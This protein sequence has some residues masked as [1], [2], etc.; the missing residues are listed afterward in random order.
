[1]TTSGGV[2]FHFTEITMLE[3]DDQLGPIEVNGQ[4]CPVDVL[5]G[6]D[7]IAGGD[8]TIAL[9][10]DGNLWFT[11]APR[12]V[13]ANSNPVKPRGR[14]QHPTKASKQKQKRKK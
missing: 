8:T 14:N 11:F 7:I 6:M 13:Q 5:I 10:N 1:M 12:S 9:K 4:P 2:T 3:R